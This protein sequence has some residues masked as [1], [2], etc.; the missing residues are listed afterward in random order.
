M[1]KKLRCRFKQ[2]FG[3]FNML[4]VHECSDTALF[5]KL[6]NPA[7]CTLEFQKQITSEAHLFFQIIPNFM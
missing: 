3:H 4:T 2:F 1:K 5:G 6:S 7:F